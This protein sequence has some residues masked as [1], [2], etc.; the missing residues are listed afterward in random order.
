VIDVEGEQFRVRIDDSSTVT[1][2]RG[3]I[4]SGAA[5]NING[6]IA[7]GITSTQ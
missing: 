6:D 5:A 3:L 7:R 1:Q 4:T 2:A